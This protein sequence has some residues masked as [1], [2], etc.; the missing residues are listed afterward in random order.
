MWWLCCIFMSANQTESLYI[1]KSYSIYKIPFTHLFP[2][3]F[4]P[5]NSYVHN[6]N[7]GQIIDKWQTKT[8]YWDCNFLVK[9]LK[10]TR[11]LS[12][13][14]YVHVQCEEQHSLHSIQEG[15]PPHLL[16]FMWFELPYTV[17]NISTSN[18]FSHIMKTQ[19]VNAG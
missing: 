10:F 16:P 15:H 4:L 11:R 5:G 12:I 13:T 17:L 8:M 3:W 6:F 1:L 7:T 9:G 14:S 18:C 2:F 19:K